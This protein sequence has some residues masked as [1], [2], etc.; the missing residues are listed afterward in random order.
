MREKKQYP[1]IDERLIKI[2]EECYPPLE[3][4]KDIDVGDLAYRGGQRSVIFKLKE[5]LKLQKGN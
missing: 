2:L 5:I 3:Y 4:T 1:P